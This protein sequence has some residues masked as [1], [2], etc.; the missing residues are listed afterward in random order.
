MMTKRYDTDKNM[1]F[2][3]DKVYFPKFLIILLYYLN[4]KIR[5]VETY[6]H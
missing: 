4:A 5:Y 2:D 6:V 1:D 3:D